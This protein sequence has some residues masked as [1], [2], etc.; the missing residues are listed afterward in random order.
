[1]LNIIL[2][3]LSFIYNIRALAS[4]QF[5]ATFARGAFPCF[6]EPAF[7]ANF[8][9]RII[10]EPRHIAISNMPKVHVNAGISLYI[11][12][13]IW[14]FKWVFTNKHPLT[15]SLLTFVHQVKTVELPGGL[16]ED[17]FDTTV[18]M[19]TYLVAY[20]VSDFLSVSETTQH[21][22]KVRQRHHLVLSVRK[23]L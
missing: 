20:I 15:S 6:D 7:K 1:M 16:L 12:L 3:L 5:E 21:G 10:R 9:I 23:S 4:T 14:S 18:K 2:L 8:T 22:V 13:C 17:H 11:V 19:S